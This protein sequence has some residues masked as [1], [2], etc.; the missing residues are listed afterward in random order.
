MV[1]LANQN[2]SVTIKADGAELTSI[3]DQA[4][5]HEFLWQADPSFWNRHAPVLFPIVS[6]LVDNTYVFQGNTY[7][8]SRHGF[9]RD[10]VFDLV[11]AE[12]NHARF[13]LSATEATKAYYPFDFDFFINYKLNDNQVTVTYQVHN[14]ATDQEM[15]YTI[16][17]HPAFNVSLNQDQTFD[18]VSYQVNPA[19]QYDLYPLTADGFIDLDL[20]HTVAVSDHNITR[21]D[22]KNDAHV[23]KVSDQT[24]VTLEDKQANVTVTMQTTDMPYVGIWSTYPADAPFVCLEPWTAPADDIH[25]SGDFT[26]KFAVSKLASGTTAQHA[27][28]LTYTKD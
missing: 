27:Y 1:T 28:T 2:L 19:G 16:G 7:Q 3:K 8:L 20:V 18:Q 4:S 6:R 9:A 25:A 14:K 13:Q 5:G 24:K 21:E 26:E 15:Y 11:T 23:C 10:M 17:G 12:D 22:F